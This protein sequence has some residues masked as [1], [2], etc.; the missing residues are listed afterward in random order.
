MERESL[1]ENG[2]V[3]LAKESGGAVRA[4]GREDALVFFAIVRSF[5]TLS[6]ILCHLWASQKNS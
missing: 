3:N 4:A 6:N 2:V 5:Y 1:G